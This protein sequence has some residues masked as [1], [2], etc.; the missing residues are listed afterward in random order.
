MT[1]SAALS[2]AAVRMIRAAAG[3]RALPV[4]LLVGGVFALGLLCGEQAHAADGVSSAQAARGP[5]STSTVPSTSVSTSTV[6][7]T[8]TVAAAS[9]STDAAR[10]LTRSSV[11]R[12]DNDSAGPDLPERAVTSP[13]DVRD[14]P[15]GGAHGGVAGTLSDARPRTAPEQ[16]PDQDAQRPGELPPL[17]SVSGLPSA[18]DLAPG[19]DS[20]SV[21]EVL[22]PSDLAVLPGLPDGSVPPGPPGLPT[23]PG[24]PAPSGLPTSPALPAPPG[25]PESPGIPASPSLPTQPDFPTLPGPT[26]PVPAPAPATPQPGSATT[27][28]ADAD[29]PQGRAGATVATVHGPRF[30]RAGTDSAVRDDAQR[31]VTAHRAPAQH[32]PVPTGDPDGALG[33]RAAVDN[34][35][36]RYGDAHAVTLDHRAPL[37]LAPGATAHAEAAGT[38]D[39][40][41]D[42]PVFP[43]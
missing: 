12:V 28:S 42:I 15:R 33:H 34:S 16:K 6:P 9:A 40:Y 17:P 7:S 29:A 22:S 8:A 30:D 5:A 31:A 1:W 32:T 27:P 36:S 21:P 2:G 37:R 39:R 26:L 43:A 3:R 10:S 14:V 35:T 38:R 41:R 24:L 11:G 25:L 13:A 23:S 19:S 18:S 20:P 4:A